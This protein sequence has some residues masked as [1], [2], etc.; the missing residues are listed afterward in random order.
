MAISAAEVSSRV[1][2]IFTYLDQRVAEMYGEGELPEEGSK[3]LSVCFDAEDDI[4]I[5]A[6][7][8]L[9][10]RGVAR[11][12]AEPGI[13]RSFEVEASASLRRDDR[14]GQT[15]ATL[16]LAAR[17]DALEGAVEQ[18]VSTN[19]RLLAAVANKPAKALPAAKKTKKKTA[20]KKKGGSRG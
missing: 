2:F 13:G 18:L 20:A 10:S 7:N 15:K 5:A 12:V 16:A 17:I 3:L 11:W 9:V 8:I 6:V 4:D 19:E 1:H 14:A